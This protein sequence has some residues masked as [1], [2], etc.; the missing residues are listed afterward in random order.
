MNRLFVILIVLMSAFFFGQAEPEKNVLLLS[1]IQD[2]YFAGGYSELV[3]PIPAI[4]NATRIPDDFRH[5]RQRIIHIKH[6]ESPQSNIHETVKV[7][8]G[9]IV[10]MDQDVN[11]YLNSGLLEYLRDNQVKRLD[12]CGMQTH[13]CLKAATRAAS[14]YG[15]DCNVIADACATKDLKF[16]DNVIKAGDV[17]YSTLAT[18]RP[19]AKVMDTVDYL[20]NH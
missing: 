8:P 9:E 5:K 4:E 7:S 13:M 16:G 1:D 12:L 6:G 2:A 18:F 14:D 3:E 11:S 20:K 10:F 17:H 15:A 19:Y